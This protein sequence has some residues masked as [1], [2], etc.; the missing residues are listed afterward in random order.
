MANVKYSLESLKESCLVVGL[1]R[2]SANQAK[3][4]ADRKKDSSNKLK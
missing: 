3:Y 2:V 1:N 4:H